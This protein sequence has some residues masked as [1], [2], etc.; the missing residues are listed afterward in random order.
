MEFHYEIKN[1]KL[2]EMVEKKAKELGISVDRLV[3][4]YV[5]R[6]LMDDNFGEDVFREVHS[7]EF[8]N[9]VNEALGLD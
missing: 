5:N 2:K 9:E 1:E 7:E 8:L 6:G 4:G 3:W